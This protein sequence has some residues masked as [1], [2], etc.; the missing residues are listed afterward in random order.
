MMLCSVTSIRHLC[1]PSALARRGA[2]SAILGLLPLA[3]LPGCIGPQVQ[4]APSSTTQESAVEQSPSV[5]VAKQDE[6]VSAGTPPPPVALP[7]PVPPVGSASSDARPE[8]ANIPVVEAPPVLVT[9]QRASYKADRAMTA[10]KTD[11]PIMETP[12]SIQV[13]PRAVMDDQ[14]VI[15]VGD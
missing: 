10:T 9:A 15:S 11:T 13:V 1:A 6:P 7:L 2:L 5:D 12:V 3:L 8:A 4:P 14:Q